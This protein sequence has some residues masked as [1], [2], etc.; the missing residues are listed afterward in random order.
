MIDFNTT[1][2]IVDKAT[3]ASLKAP[4][5]CN[6]ESKDSSKNGEDVMWTAYEVKSGRKIQFPETELGKTVFTDENEA[7]DALN[8]LK[9]ELI[10]SALD[11]AALVRKR[12]AGANRNVFDLLKSVFDEETY[13][14]LQNGALNHFLLTGSSTSKELILHTASEELL[15]KSYAHWYFDPNG[16]DWGLPAWRCSNCYAKNDNLGM[17][18]NISPYLFEGGKFCPCCGKP[19]KP[20]QG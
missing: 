4:L 9:Y 18:K 6:V 5:K 3:F 11:E 7:V 16:C 8:R 13:N 19:M 1:V 14:R 17:D 10:E 20:S 12:L 15:Q 2:Y